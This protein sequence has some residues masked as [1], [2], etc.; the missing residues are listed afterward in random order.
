MRSS[1]TAWR[2]S[3]G[4]PSGTVTSPS[5]WLCMLWR[6]NTTSTRSAPRL[7]MLRVTLLPASRQRRTRRR[8]PGCTA[9]PR[10]AVGTT[11]RQG[12]KSRSRRWPLQKPLRRTAWRTSRQS[13]SASAHRGKPCLRP[14]PRSKRR[15]WPAACGTAWACP[16]SGTSSTCS[17][18][19][20]SLGS[21]GRRRRWRPRSSPACRSLSMPPSRVGARSAGPGPATGPMIPSPV[22]SRCAAWS[23]CRTPRAT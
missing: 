7:P 23:T 2:G 20:R 12:P 5:L 21:C 16:P 22:G 9:S 18:R 19:P 10:M 1:R 15:A 17:P 8:S 13:S 6:R 14:K 4:R 3:C 11:S